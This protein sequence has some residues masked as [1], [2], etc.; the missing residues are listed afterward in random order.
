MQP[1]NSVEPKLI[2]KTSSS[3]RTVNCQKAAG[4]IGPQAK[5]GTWQNI[6]RQPFGGTE[7]WGRLRLRQRRSGVYIERG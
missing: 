7:L 2:G 4:R 6:I 3:H 1:R 5:L